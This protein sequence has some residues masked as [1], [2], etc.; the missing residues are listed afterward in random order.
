MVH[1]WSLTDYVTHGSLASIQLNSFYV[2]TRK[3]W[4]LSSWNA[5]CSWSLWTLISWFPFYVWLPFVIL[6]DSSLSVFLGPQELITSYGTKC[7]L[8][9][10]KSL[11]VVQ[12]LFWAV[13]TNI[14]VPTPSFCLD[15]FK[16]V[17]NVQ[18][19]THHLLTFLLSPTSCFQTCSPSGISS[20][21][22]IKCIQV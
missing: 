8:L 6:L 4:L 21:H 13:V 19:R 3:H 12:F 20:G 14:Q 7:V 22:S 9:N 5:P 18:N 16:L 15:D 10:P 1:Y 17:Q 2:N 11:L